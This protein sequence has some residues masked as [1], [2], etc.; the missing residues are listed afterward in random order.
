MEFNE[1]FYT[2]KLCNLEEINS[3]KK[4]YKNLSRNR[5]EKQITSKEIELYLSN[6]PQRKVLAQTAAP[7]SSIKCLRRK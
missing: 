7:L 2:K 4:N 1:Q 5:K 6:Y 3:Q